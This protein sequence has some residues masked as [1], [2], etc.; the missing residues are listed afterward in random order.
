M[1]LTVHPLPLHNQNLRGPA[2]LSFA[3]HGKRGLRGASCSCS[4]GSPSASSIAP[5]AK[6]K[7]HPSPSPAKGHCC[8]WAPTTLRCRGWPHHGPLLI[9]PGGGREI[10]LPCFYFAAAGA[11]S[12][13]A[14]RGVLKT[15]K[16]DSSNRLSLCS[17]PSAHQP[18]FI[19]TAHLSPPMPRPPTPS[20]GFSHAHAQHRAL[21]CCWEGAKLIPMEIY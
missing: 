9:A 12:C 18:C 1:L 3:S 15:P 5:G 7:L 10:F 2:E 20:P 16:S 19:Y 11:T 8:C 17:F 6:C 14:P 21:P 4:L 13:S